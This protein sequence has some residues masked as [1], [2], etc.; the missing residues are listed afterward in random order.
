MEKSSPHGGLPPRTYSFITLGCKSNQYD[1][2]AMAASLRQSGLAPSDLDGADVIVV[3][4]CMVTG[5]T[6]AQCR[7]AIRR[8]RKANSDAR[9]VVVGCLSKG[10]PDQIRSMPEADLV[11]GPSEKGM[12]THF[13][14][15]ADHGSWTDWPEDPAVSL[16][17]RDRGFLKVQDG[18]DH[19]CSYCIVPSVR[20]PGRSLAPA[21]VVSSVR[22]LMEKGFAEVVLTGIHLGMYGRDLSPPATLEDL[23]DR[24]M[25]NGLPGR[26]RLSSIEPLEVT[27]RLLGLM[28]RF[29]GAVCRH[30][31]IPLQS[32]SDPILNAM[33]R[34]YG[35]TDF[36]AAVR[37]A[38]AA[39]PGIGI[40]CD[41][42]CGFPGETE[43]DFSRTVELVTDL[44]IPYLHAFPFS[45]RPGTAAASMGDDVPVRVKRARVRRLTEL[46]GMNRKRFLAGQ[47]GSVLGVVPENRRL[48][49]GSMAL[50]DNYTRVLIAGDVGPLAGT[51]VRVR[52][53]GIEGDVL[54]GVVS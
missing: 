50:G 40:G 9:L 32:G 39:V 30:L 1:S 42:I 49:R 46:A 48:E 34:P 20:G 31:H 3:N 13:L 26:I 53:T 12:L 22:A 41:V 47:V 29:P 7:K 51:I 25:V 14:N 37:A 21:T 8:A 28:A 15:L 43:E 52:I 23:L 10:D 44:H 18:C 38:R 19:R 35:S 5:S 6:E 16:E 27:S 36:E 17:H 11:L 24:L 4:T 2:A 45:S 33:N 54:T